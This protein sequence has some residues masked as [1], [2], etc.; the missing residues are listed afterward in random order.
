V[1][2]AAALARVGDCLRQPDRARRVNTAA[3]AHLVALAAEARARFVFVSTDLVF[4]GD[5]GSYREDD[6]ATPRS[7]Y[8]QTKRDAEEVVLAASGNAVVRLSLLFGP[9]RNGRM[10]FFDEQL[11]A[12]R[13]GPG[14]TL[15]SDEWRTPLD[16]ATAARALWTVASSDVAGVLHVGGPERLSRFEMGQRLA[17]FVG[18]D[19]SRFTA[20]RRDDVPSPEPRPR[21]TSLDSSRWQDLFPS[22]PWPSFEAALRELLAR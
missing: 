19:P 21:D 12:L 22:Q 16:L 10:S 18:A 5:R 9:S 15:F 7:I 17:A 8:G 14:V 11:A 3:T 13:G 1:I 20:A 4:D 6:A 2:H